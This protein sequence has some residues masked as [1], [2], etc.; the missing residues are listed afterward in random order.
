VPLG[1][2]VIG[3]LYTLVPLLVLCTSVL[4]FRA[5]RRD[6][7]LRRDYW[8]GH[9][10]KDAVFTL[11]YLV[12]LVGGVGVLAGW[13]WG[14]AV[15][16]G[17]SWAMLVLV[18]LYGAMRLWAW[19]TVTSEMGMPMRSGFVGN[20]LAGLIVVVLLGSAIG[21]LRAYAADSPRADAEVGAR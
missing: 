14:P 6:G 21:Y 19:V 17:V 3:I 2:L 5:M 10:W 4:A 7:G 8:Q 16:E 15:V 18:L 12:S 13:G 9:A 11:V 20:W 1:L